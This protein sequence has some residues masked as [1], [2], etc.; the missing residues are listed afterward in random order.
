M[1]YVPLQDSQMY[2]NRNPNHAN[3]WFLIDGERIPCNKE[4]LM[5]M[6][7]YFVVTFGPSW[8]NEN[9]IE[10]PRRELR[11][12][13]PQ[14]YDHNISAKSFKE[15]LKYA[16]DVPR[17]FT[18]D[19]V[20]GVMDM[21]NSLSQTQAA[22]IFMECEDF[23][24]QSI[25]KNTMLTVYEWAGLYDLKSLMKEIIM[26][27]EIALKS[28]SFHEF[29]DHFLHN[30]LRD[31]TLPCEERD[32]FNAC[33][34]W[35]RKACRKN[36]LDPTNMENLR[37][38]L[39]IDDFDLLHQIRFTAMTSRDA[40]TC[41]RS[42]PDLFE[43][44][45]LREIIRMVGHHRNDFQSNKFN[46]TSRYCTFEWSNGPHLDCSRFIAG[47]KGKTTHIIKRCETT[48]FT[49][50][51]RMTLKGIKCEVSRNVS[52]N[53]HLEINEIN[54]DD[55]SVQRHSADMTVHF[56]EAQTCVEHNSFLAQIQSNENILL[57]PNYTYEISI[58]F[59]NGADDLN[60]LSSMK[61][62]VRFN[63][64]LVVHFDRK[65]KYRG[66]VATL[67][68]RRFDDRKLLRKII[69]NPKLWI[70]IIVMA[71]IL[72]FGTALY[73]SP[74]S[75]HYMYQIIYD[76]ALDVLYYV[77]IAFLILCGCV[78]HS[79]ASSNSNDADSLWS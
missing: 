26:H 59:N 40:A 46:W 60:S 71:L 5:A 55:R 13:V 41:I 19:N 25:T 16:Y 68:I 10:F 37:S 62:K 44:D 39:K 65:P 50:N 45:E 53:I 6:S 54:S 24:K 79:V 67:S 66:I 58:T 7:E 77:C 73:V 28:R 61:Q 69:H 78:V 2:L 9:V 29:P 74:Q 57:R 20:K 42:Y 32:I 52:K 22:P 48:R 31:N 64:D 70:W 8:Y 76:F 75:F 33:M 38:Q 17:K 30:I 36:R 43:K 14:Q 1:A 51:R 12:G 21:A 11:E 47:D 4:I 49:C 15:F 72:C 18:M 27:T 56:N 35:A 34:A 63:H 23:L 3:V